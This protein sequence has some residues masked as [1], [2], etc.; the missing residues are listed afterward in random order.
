MTALAKLETPLTPVST[1][2]VPWEPIGTHGLHRKILGHDEASGHVTFLLDIPAGW[3]GGG[4]A[5]YH[6]CCEEV[7][8]LSGSVTLDGSHY[9]HAGDYF[10]RPAHVVH[11]IDEKSEEGARALVR[12]DARMELLLVPEPDSPQEYPLPEFNDGRGHVFDLPLDQAPPFASS[13]FP[14]DWDVRALSDNPDTGAR[15]LLVAIPAGWHGEATGPGQSWE[16]FCLDG[17]VSSAETTYGPGD[18][19]VG[20]G[21]TAPFAACK[22]ADGARFILWCFDTP[23]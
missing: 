15:T 23:Q 10:Y 2:K 9:W 5:H 18:Y 12:C 20:G 22:S 19:T 17:E 8:L 6:E 16:A 21:D 1:S 4:V 14:A 13:A 7:L 3:H 11:G